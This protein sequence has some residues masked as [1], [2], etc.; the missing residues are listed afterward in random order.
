[1][2]NISATDF[3]KPTHYNSDTKNQIWMSI[4]TDSHDNFCN[5]QS[6]YAHLL[7]S[8]FP[9][10]HSDRDLTINQI[11]ERDYK[12]QCLSGGAAAESSGME[13]TGGTKPGLEKEEGAHFIKDEELE[14]LIAAGEDAGGR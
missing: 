14:D 10:G 6:A 11:L 7:A 13:G 8:I 12:E 5:C 3:I 4:I 1:M 9:P 2:N